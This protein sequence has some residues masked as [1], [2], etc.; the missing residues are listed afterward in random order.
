M[1]LDHLK[2]LPCEIKSNKYNDAVNLVT[3]LAKYKR[4]L[5]LIQSEASRSHYK[6][7]YNGNN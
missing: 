1:L 2:S 3:N 5:T 4:V 6:H 7:K